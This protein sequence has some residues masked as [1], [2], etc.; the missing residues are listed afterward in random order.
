MIV[1]SV[2][3][4]SASIDQ[5]ELITSGSVGIQ[6]HFGFSSDW[7]GLMRT[8]V[9]RKGDS[10]QKVDV[11]LD[12]T[13]EC[14]VPWEVLNEEG[15]VLFIGVYGTNEAGTIVI[16]TVWVT[17]GVVKPGTAPSADPTTAPTPSIWAQILAVANDAEAAAGDAL[18]IATRAETIATAAYERTA[19]DA[20]AAAEAALAAQTA[21]SNAE[22]AETGAGAQALRS[23]GFA[24][25]T[26]N[27]SDVGSGSPYYQNNSRYFRDEANTAA[28]LSSDYSVVSEK[29]ATGAVNGTPV[30]STEP[31]Y[32]NSAKY[33]CD[34]AGEKAADAEAAMLAAQEAQEAIED[35]TATAVGLAAGESPTVTKSIV[36]GVVNLEFGIPKGDKGDKGDKGETGEKGAKGDTGDQGATPVLSIGTVTTGE[37]GSA[38][39]ASITGP[40]AAPV[41]NLSIPRGY[42]LEI[43]GLVASVADLPA[44]ADPYTFYEVGTQAPY[45]VYMFDGTNW[46]DQGTLKGPKGDKGDKGDTGEQ[47]EQGIQ[48]IQGEKG[49]T[50]ATGPQGPK[51]DTGPQGEKGD[52][53]DTGA[54][55]PTGPRGPSG[56]NYALCD[57]AASTQ[58]KQI[59]VSGITEL[60]DG[61][62]VRVLFANEQGY[63]G[64]PALDLNSLGAWPINRD[65]IGM[66]GQHEWVG[67][68]VLDL[69]YDSTL[70]RWII[71]GGERANEGHYGKT[72]LF[73]SVLSPSTTM[74]ATPASVKQV[75]DKVGD[76]VLDSGF[77][78]TD[79]TGAA[80]ELRNTLS[81]LGLTVV[82]GK[83]CAVYNVA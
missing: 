69:V 37:P 31:Q 16:P 75:N 3:T 54:T 23:E 36:E 34:E 67:G 83:L 14:I 9:F 17:A 20:E 58:K 4:R 29:W 56:I 32:H 53:G 82:D 27:G 44:D 25:G 81:N 64:V 13:N 18:T 79:L 66:A 35:M 8:A 71:V 24:A 59:S 80:N 41:L 78:A 60:V 72:K 5:K 50:G 43:S 52:T 57:T 62:S 61:L 48:G 74:A 1:I 19:A 30:P 42:G 26:Q 49:D 51:G 73:T 38:A 33:Y 22:N 21:Q 55:G 65:K 45:E 15:E 63:N 10:G 68:E 77:T 40:T 28:S 70:Q 39:E 12:S 47:G 2:E 76:G 6:V 46:V 7:N 11:V